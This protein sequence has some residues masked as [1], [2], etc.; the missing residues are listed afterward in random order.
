VWYKFEYRV[1]Q[2]PKPNDSENSVIT[3][4]KDTENDI[5]F[6]EPNDVS[7]LVHVR[8]FLDP[9]P[10]H[11]RIPYTSVR[12]LRLTEIEKPGAPDK[13]VIRDYSLGILY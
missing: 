9:T 12:P 10:R 8:R 6:S 3:E 4:I 1:V 2:H 11:N 5:T 7:A 13:R